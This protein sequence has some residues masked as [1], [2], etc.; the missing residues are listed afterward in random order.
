MWLL[1]AVLVA[2]GVLYVGRLWWM[3]PHLPAF[4]AEQAFGHLKKQVSFGPRIPGTLAHES[5]LSYLKSTLSQYA[6][7]VTTEPFTWKNRQD[8]TKVLTGTN[9]VASFNAQASNRILL[10]AHWDTRPFADQDPNPDRRKEPVPGANDGASGVAVLLEMARILRENRPDVGVDI[11]LTDMEDLGDYDA[12]A[13]PKT[14]NPFS[15]GAQKFVEMHPDYNPSFGILLDMVGDADLQFP[16]ER[17]SSANASAI[18][19]KVWT[20]AQKVGATAFVRTEGQAITDDHLPFLRKGIPVI[21]VIDF[22]YPQWH[23]TADTPEHC[24][25]KSLEQVGKTLVQVIY[26][27]S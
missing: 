8:T 19:D 10:L 26:G 21:D 5:C 9:L 1:L 2:I 6:D 17:F 16:I 3:T 18:V 14:R 25:A 13:Q 24:R 15:I 12:E 22:T 11:L 27:E 4:G 7:Q 23:T 20:A